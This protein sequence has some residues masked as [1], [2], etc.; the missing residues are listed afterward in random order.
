[1]VSR[2]GLHAHG[3]WLRVRLGEESEMERASQ[4]TW[5]KRVERWKASGLTAAEFAAELGISG[6]SLKWW[7]WRLGHGKKSAAARKSRLPARVAR[8]ASEVVSPLTFVE[9][10]SPRGEPLEVVLKSGV[11]IRVP[12]DFDPVALGRLVDLLDRQR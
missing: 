10:S 2:D 4:E 9:M 7:K 1:M 8:S 6:H 12:V 5:A 3:L 11:R